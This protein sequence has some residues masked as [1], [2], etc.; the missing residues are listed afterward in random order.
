[1]R[2]ILTSGAQRGDAGRPGRHRQV[3]RGR[4]RWRRRGKTPTC[5][6][7]R[8]GRD[9]RRRV[10]GLAASQI[11][12]EVLAG[13]GLAARNIARWLATQ[14]RLEEPPRTGAGRGED[15]PWRLRA[16]DLVVVDESA[17]ANTAD[18]AA[19]HARVPRPRRRSCCWSATT[20]S[21][22]RSA[23]AARMDL[24]AALDGAVAARAGRDPPLPPRLGRPGVAAAAGPRRDRARRVPQARPVA[25]LW[26]DRAGRGQRRPRPGWPTP[27][28]ASTRLLIV[29]T[30]EQAA[31]LSAQLR[32]DLVR[33]GRVDDEHAVPLGL[34]GTFAG[35]GDLVQARL[36]DWDLAGYAGNRRGPINREQ[37]RVLDIH[38]DGDLRRRPP[39]PTARHDHAARRLRRRARRAGLRLHRAR[40][41]GPDRGHRAHRRP[42][43]PPAPEALYVGLTRGRHAQHRP[44]RHQ[45]RPRRR[46]ARQSP[47]P[48]CTAP[49]R[50]CSR[51]R[52]R[53]PTRS[54]PRWPR[55]PRAPPRP[56]RCAP[57]PSCSPTPPNS[58]PPAAPPAGSTNSS[59][60]D[61]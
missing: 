1:M 22:P 55:P 17:M 52:S 54:C 58:P 43:A 38:A 12:T 15:R 6:P 61:A 10:V 23:P 9:P 7:G 41:P 53:P 29:D 25:G 3:V 59:P 32:A 56:G 57:R 18:L 34:Q 40:R 31:R 47:T 37:Y 50:P 2:G 26:R 27:S 20:A 51:A 48:R 24:I 45:G 4:R 60:K 28:T 14:D 42:P 46:T 11:A 39:A 21:S 36:N 8:T 30:N 33:L 13:E 5:G 16:G 35:V 49:R 19:I 44:R